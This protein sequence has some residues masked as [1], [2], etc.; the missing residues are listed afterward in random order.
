MLQKQK[1]SQRSGRRFQASAKQDS[2]EDT[3]PSAAAEALKG[4]KL[5]TDAT[6][7]KPKPAGAKQS[8]QGV[9][10]SSTHD[11]DAEPNSKPH[12]QPVSQATQNHAHQQ[13]QQQAN[14]LPAYTKA[15]VPDHVVAKREEIARKAKR[16]RAAFEGTK[17]SIFGDKDHAR[18]STLSAVC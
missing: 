5:S 3:A 6:E 1:Q 15:A 12:S 8:Q 10:Q 13:R 4:Y 7:A 2:S 9:V 14:E 17:C 18:K 11:F 16:S